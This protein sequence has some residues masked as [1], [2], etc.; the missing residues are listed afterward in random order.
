MPGRGAATPGMGP[1]TTPGTMTEKGRATLGETEG[2]PGWRGG[3]SC[4]PCLG[5]IDNGEGVRDGDGDGDDEGEGGAVSRVCVRG[6][7]L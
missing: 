1:G 6:G 2:E 7:T 4:L 3:I 5:G